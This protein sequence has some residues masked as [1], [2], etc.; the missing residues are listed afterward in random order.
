MSFSSL[1]KGVRRSAVYHPKPCCQSQTDLADRVGKPE[2][3]QLLCHRHRRHSSFKSSQ[4]MATVS[5]AH[6]L[7]QNFKTLVKSRNEWP[8]GALWHSTAG[9]VFWGETLF[10]ISIYLLHYCRGVLIIGIKLRNDSP[11]MSASQTKSTTGSS[12]PGN[13]N[14]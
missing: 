6:A 11:W 9:D 10:S 1:P 2:K 3:M 12:I 4:N 13:V 8:L 7:D 5:R 14:T